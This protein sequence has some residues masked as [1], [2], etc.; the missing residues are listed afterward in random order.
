MKAYLYIVSGCLLIT[1]FSCNRTLYYPAIQEENLDASKKQIEY[2]GLCTFEDN[3][4]YKLSF[5]RSYLKDSTED[6]NYMYLNTFA[7]SDEKMNKAVYGQSPVILQ[8]VFIK[9][10][11]NGEV[12]YIAPF[13][14][15]SKI[16]DEI[17]LNDTTIRKW[18]LKGYVIAPENEYVRDSAKID[19]NESFQ[20]ILYRPIKSKKVKDKSV[21]APYTELR[22]EIYEK[23]I[24]G[25]SEKQVEK[26]VKKAVKRKDKLILEME[27][28]VL[29]LIKYKSRSGEI[30]IDQAFVKKGIVSQGS[31]NIWIKTEEV[32]NYGVLS[33]Y[34]N[35]PAKLY[36]KSVSPEESKESQIEFENFQ[37]RVEP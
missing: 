24:G 34:D 17:I 26:V 9:F 23:N 25:K 27:P 13:K 37:K 11:S 5:Y 1:I 15:N 20:L 8:E 28:M 16:S 22:A 14:Y 31:T 29:R 4:Y 19:K 30:Y 21:Y 18:I 32:L 36:F 7:P 35:R 3:Q 2:L 6:F 10:E 12:S 33:I